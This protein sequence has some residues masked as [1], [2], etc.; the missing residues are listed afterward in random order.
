[1]R[2]VAV[3]VESEWERPLLTTSQ[4]QFCAAPQ[5]APWAY[6]YGVCTSFVRFREGARCEQVRAFAI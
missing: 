5:T 2:V 4:P 1:M 3:D 6:G